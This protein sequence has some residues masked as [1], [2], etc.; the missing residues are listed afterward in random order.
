M[1]KIKDYFIGTEINYF[2][3]GIFI[4]LSE[5][6]SQKELKILYELKHPAV[7]KKEKKEKLEDEN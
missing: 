6:T 5:K 3:K 4:Y 2:K 7:Y 1:Y